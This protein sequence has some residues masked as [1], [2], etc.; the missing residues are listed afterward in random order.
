M[1]A[2][3]SEKAPVKIHELTIDSSQRQ[4]LIKDKPMDLTFIEFNILIYISKKTWF[5]FHKIP[6]YGY[7]TW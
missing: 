5:G 1:K 7:V 3:D 4:V 6:D 2:N